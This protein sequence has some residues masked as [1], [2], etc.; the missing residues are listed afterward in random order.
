MALAVIAGRADVFRY[1]HA[2]D[3][4]VIDQRTANGDTLL[5][6]VVEF[7]QHDIIRLF[8]SDPSIKFNPI[9]V[10]FCGRTPLMV[11]CMYGDPVR[12][13]LLLGCTSVSNRRTLLLATCL[14]GQNVLHYACYYFSGDYPKLLERI[15]HH[16]QVCSQTNKEKS[17]AELLTKPDNYGQRPIHT[18]CSNGR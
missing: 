6:V 3:P 16:V 7:Q 12:F 15:R 1:L 5:H 8:L 11:A 13:D 18:A 14:S 4:K 2:R 17:L 9:I 10:G